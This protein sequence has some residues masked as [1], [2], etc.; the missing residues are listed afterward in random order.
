MSSL[1]LSISKE[2]QAPKTNPDPPANPSDAVLKRIVEYVHSL[3][4]EKMKS[5]NIM[6]KK[7]INGALPEGFPQETIEKALES[8]SD[9]KKWRPVLALPT[10]MYRT[11][12]F[13]FS[14]VN[15]VKWCN[16]NFFGAKNKGD[17]NNN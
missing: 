6:S 11:C 14:K 8:R 13:P 5:S 1:S 3:A 2:N 4:E 9:K 12:L 16:N 7:K 15:Y 17:S 10:E